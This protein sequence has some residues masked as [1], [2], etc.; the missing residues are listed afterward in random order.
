MSDVA[1]PKPSPIIGPINGETSMAPMTTAVE[2]T[3]NPREQMNIAKTR[4]QRL[5]PL[6]TTPLSI[7]SEIIEKSSFSLFKRKL[8]T[9]LV[10]NL[11]ILSI[12]KIQKLEG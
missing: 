1:R 9:K 7:F 11:N 10:M 5:V 6:K 12:N 8:S 4:I 2:F 3:F